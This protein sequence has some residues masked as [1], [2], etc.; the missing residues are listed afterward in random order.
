[1][2][3]AV[4]WVK[5][6]N[7]LNWTARG[8]EQK[9]SATAKSVA[10]G[11]GSG[12][13]RLC[14][15]VLRCSHSACK[16]IIEAALAAFAALLNTDQFGAGFGQRKW[17]NVRGFRQAVHSGIDRRDR[18]GCARAAVHLLIEMSKNNAGRWQQPRACAHNFRNGKLDISIRDNG[19]RTDDHVRLQS[20]G[21]QGPGIG[22]P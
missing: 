13:L 8:L 16:G 17:A 19:A 20:I 14:D 5:P 3:I 10:V 1:M 2:C 22:H 9:T 15:G 12:R 4:H 11:I 7:I 6:R 21:V 18:H